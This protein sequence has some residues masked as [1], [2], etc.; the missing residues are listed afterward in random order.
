[1]V[2]MI[3]IGLKCSWIKMRPRTMDILRAI[4]IRA[5]SSFGGEVKLS[6]PCH[7][8]LLHVKKLHRHE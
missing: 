4:E 1:V 7:K 5:P 6:I 2:S 3:A 8:I